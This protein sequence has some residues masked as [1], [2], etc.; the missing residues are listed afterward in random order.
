MRSRKWQATPRRWVGEAVRSR[1]W[2]PVGE[3]R[4]LAAPVGVAATCARPAHRPRVG[5]SAGSRRSVTAPRH[6]PVRSCAVAAADCRRAPAAARN[7]PGPSTA[8]PAAHARADAGP[9]HGHTGRCATFSGA[10]RAGSGPSGLPC[11]NADRT[12]GCARNQRSIRQSGERDLDPEGRARALLA[13][14]PHAAT[15]RLHHV[16][17]DGQ[18]QP[19][20]AAGSSVPL[21]RA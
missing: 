20:A 6:R 11:A 15:V 2:P 16:P 14:D 13:L 18:A 19:R 1:S 5:R 7:R 4:P 17:H 12:A 8:P 21:T 9:G 10:D 3:L